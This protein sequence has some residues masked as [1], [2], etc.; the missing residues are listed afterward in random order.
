M[1]IV[2]GGTM[3]APDEGKTVF[4][5]PHKVRYV[6][7]G[8]DHPYALIE[9]TAP[10]GVPSPPLHV[11]QATDETFFVVE[12]V[13]GFQAGEETFDGSPG[14]YVVVPKGVAHTFWNRGATAGKVLLL[15]SPP[16]FASY[17]AALSER[18]AAAGDSPEQAV[19]VRQGLSAN[20][21]ISVVGP[22]RQGEI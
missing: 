22:Q 9:W 13:F 16:G 5:G 8:A 4:V 11:H 12:G 10:P 1:S 17:F 6:D 7:P 18:L 3:L 20:Y 21:D 14:A 19:R 15:I 2:S